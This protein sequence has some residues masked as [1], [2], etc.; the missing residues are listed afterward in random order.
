MYISK[1]ELGSRRNSMSMYE[2]YRIILR[3][4][5][6]RLRKSRRVTMEMMADSLG[7]TKDNYYRIEAGRQ[8][9]RVE[10]MPIIAERLNTNID[11][12]FTLNNTNTQLEPNEMMLIDYVRKMEKLS[13]VK[14]TTLVRE[15]QSRG[16]TDDKIDLLLNLTRNL[17]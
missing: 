16:F 8:S 17:K 15:I 10:Y 3:A 13:A 5:L 9:L 12:L 11:A 2:T 7:M 6:K 1:I 14:I 4:N